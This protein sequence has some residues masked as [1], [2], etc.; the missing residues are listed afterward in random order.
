MS[1]VME[2]MLLLSTY[3]GKSLKEY[4]P[5]RIKRTADYTHAI[6][7][8]IGPKNAYI[9]YNDAFPGGAL[10]YAS[11][12]AQLGAGKY[13]E[14][15]ATRQTRSG[16]NTI[17][18]LMA[19]QY[20]DMEEDVPHPDFCNLPITGVTSVRMDTQD[21]GKVALFAISGRSFP[22]H[23]HAD[24]GS[25]IVE[26]DKRAIL[27]DR[28]TCNYEH[29]YSSMV[30][31]SEVHNMITAVKDGVHLG[32]QQELF[33][34]TEDMHGGK[35]SGYVL[36]AEYENGK[37]AYATDITD[38]WKGIFRKNVRY[39][40]A[41]EPHEIKIRDSL[42]IDTQYE[43]CF[44]LNC[45]G[46]ITK[47]GNDYLITDGDIRVRVHLENWEA[48]REEFGPCGIDGKVRPVNRLCIFTGGKQEYDLQTTITLKK[49]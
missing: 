38:A 17:L 12:M 1:C 35:Y 18:G 8:T 21:M 23:G 33:D 41:D 6:A 30:H 20:H 3:Y 45:Y 44:I 48:T 31:K 5:D 26:A 39:I 43:V 32:Q 46:E 11:F 42:E 27:I 29:S 37:F 14:S 47:D 16:V 15:E 24:K 49:Q 28:G 10:G 4:V 2:A 7:S 9:P 34:I 19:Y 13:W 22:G 36:K 40:T 25:F